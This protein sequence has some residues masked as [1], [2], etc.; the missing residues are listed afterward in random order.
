MPIKEQVLSRI[1]AE[2]II[3]IVRL[4]DAETVEPT[5][6]A[7]YAGGLSAIEITMGTPQALQHIEKFAQHPSILIGAGSVSDAE[8]ARRAILAGARFIVTPFSK[9]SVI[10]TAMLYRVPI[11]SGAFTPGEM[12][13]A[14]EWGADIVKVFP[15]H[16]LGVAYARSVLASM[17]HLPLMPTGGI[18][19]DNAHEWLSAGAV[20]LGVGSALVDPRAVTEGNYQQ[21]TRNAEQWSKLAAEAS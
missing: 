2:K 1:V 10:E 4:A 3:A 18:T 8:S 13:Q 5:V 14:L 15:A 7:I 12:Q 21:I 20:A 6:E 16:T 11:F 9:A 17:P 19:L